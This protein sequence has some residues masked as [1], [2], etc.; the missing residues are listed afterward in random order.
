MT[1][2]LRS[3]NDRLLPYA[4][5][6]EAEGEAKRIM[7]AAHT[8]ESRMRRELESQLQEAQEAVSVAREQAKAIMDVAR[9]QASRIVEGAKAE[10]AE[11]LAAGKS[12]AAD[13]E[14]RARTYADKLLETARRQAVNMITSAERKAEETAGQALRAIREAERLDGVVKALKN[15]IEGYGDEYLIPGVTLLD[16]LAD[17]YDFS[18]ASRDYKLVKEQVKRMMR[19]GRAATCD[20][21][22]A[23]RRET[24]IRFVA[25]AFNGKV[26]TALSRLRHDNYGKLRQEIL[27]AFALVNLNGQ[28]FRSA[29]VEAGY[30]E[31]RLEEL[32]LGT[33]LQEMKLADMAEQKR[34][35]DQIR[36][37]QRAQREFERAL[38]D[39]AKEE[40]ALKKAMEKVRGAYEVAGQEQKQKYEMQ[41]REMEQRLTEAEVKNQRALSMAQQTRAGH[42]Y[43]ISNV[44]SFGE[45]IFK[46]GM[47]RRLEP[48]DRVRELGDASVPFE[49]DVHAMIFSENAPALE[50]DLQKRFF[51]QQVN[52]VN[53]RKEFFRV[54]LDD[55]R[56]V[57]EEQN[58]GTIHWTLAAEARHYRETLALEQRLASDPVARQAWLAEQRAR[59]DLPE[60]LYEDEAVEGDLVA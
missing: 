36:E 27:D 21:V 28:A 40:D 15:R 59:L 14:T 34:I 33:V 45:D 17:D 5:V 50:R 3:E 10:R 1:A 23:N 55:L 32:R 7:D 60:T 47:T 35:K 44:G 2:S 39:A 12:Q 31:L 48:F 29:Q 46:I 22:E 24:A 19:D 30:L 54:S 26:E 20:Y 18:L 37:E 6:A 58:V 9:I 43:V 8:A 57:V 51:L 53:L 25:D 16:K 13:V 52:K 42:V 56:K 41:L 49:F 38:R 11:T 4:R